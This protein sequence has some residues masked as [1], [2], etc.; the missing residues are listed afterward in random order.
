MANEIVNKVIEEDR[1]AMRRDVDRGTYPRETPKPRSDASN[2]PVIHRAWQSDHI[3][4]TA[5]DAAMKKTAKK[6]KS[7][8][9]SESP[10]PTTR[11]S[12]S[13]PS[14]PPSPRVPA[15]PLPPAPAAAVSRGDTGTAK[16]NTLQWKQ[17]V[18]STSKVGREDCPNGA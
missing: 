14:T 6:S 9:F 16:H 4:R 18:P 7:V 15:L 12:S 17:V 5:E 13:L 11:L 10:P 3:Q 2:P 1:S 8:R